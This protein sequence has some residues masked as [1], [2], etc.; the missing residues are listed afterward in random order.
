MTSPQRTALPSLAPLTAKDCSYITRRFTKWYRLAPVA[1]GSNR[2]DM[3]GTSLSFQ[4]AREHPPDVILAAK[5]NRGNDN[6]PRLLDRQKPDRSPVTPQE[7]D[8][9]MDIR[10]QRSDA[11]RLDQPID[12]QTKRANTLGGALES[13]LGRI[14]EVQIGREQM[15]EDQLE[16]AISL[17]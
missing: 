6:R 5:E 14:S 8:A 17:S 7:A 4:Q 13:F 15:V 12:R 16:I 2:R 3:A 11:W 10:S 1:A 9:G